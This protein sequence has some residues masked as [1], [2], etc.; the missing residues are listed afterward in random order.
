MKLLT[1]G[2]YLWTRTVG[3]TAVGQ[4]VDTASH[5]VAFAGNLDAA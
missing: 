3:S 4:A 5:V 1:K 2:R